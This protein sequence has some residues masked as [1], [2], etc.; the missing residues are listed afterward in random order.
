MFVVLIQEPTVYSFRLW[1]LLIKPT[2]YFILKKELR[3]FWNFRVFHGL[4]WVWWIL[5]L[6]KSFLHFI[7][8]IIFE[9]CLCLQGLSQKATK[10]ILVTFCT[11]FAVY[12]YNCNCTGSSVLWALH[13]DKE[14]IPTCGFAHYEQL[15]MLF[16][17]LHVF[18]NVVM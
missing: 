13:L 7:F 10:I 11:S 6:H 3:L 14:R 17:F 2:E 15:F 1:M 5:I 4:I 16:R 9:D 18:R 12:N 8:D